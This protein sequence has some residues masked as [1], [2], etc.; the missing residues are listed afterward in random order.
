MS[1]SFGVQ[2]EPIYGT[3]GEFTIGSDDNR[4]RAQFLLTKMKPGSEGIWENSLASQMVPWREVF[5]I[6]DLTFDELLQRD[7]DDSRV[8]HDLIPYLLGESGAFARF[9]P[10]ILAVLVPK[11]SEKT[12][13]ESYYPAPRQ[14]SELS[15]SFG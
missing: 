4:V 10:P 9:F 14:V 3:Y 12:G 8:A 1:F 13:I 7:L 15:I 6:E 5:N 11:K 2:K